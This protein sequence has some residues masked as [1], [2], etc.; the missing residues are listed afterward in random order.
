[1]EHAKRRP[2]P[3]DPGREFVLTVPPSDTPT[4]VRLRFT[5]D[6]V[7]V[8]AS[9]GGLSPRSRRPETALRVVRRE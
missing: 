9:A 2:L 4:L 5:R 7:S 8:E 3:I 6:D 1:M